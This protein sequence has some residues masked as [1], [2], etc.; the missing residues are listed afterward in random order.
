MGSLEATTKEMRDF[1]ELTIVECERMALP[2]HDVEVRL[3]AG[4]LQRPVQMP[5]LI[6]RHEP[7]PIAVNDQ[8][9]RRISTHVG[10]R[11]GSTRLIEAVLDVTP[12]HLRH[13]AE[14]VKMGVAPAQLDHVGRR[15]K[16]ARRVNSR[17]TDT[18]GD[19]RRQMPARRLTGNTKTAGINAV[20]MAIRVN[21]IDCGEGIFQLGGPAMR[22]TEQAILHRCHGESMIGQITQ[23]QMKP[24]M[25]VLPATPVIPHDYRT[26]LPR[27][28]DVK[29]DILGRPSVF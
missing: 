6:W 22:S 29:V 14:S 24:W 25:S 1:V 16:D 12:E 19:Q 26:R 21:P 5:R 17:A 8:E 27:R 9:R 20:A 28:G 10:K 13:D 3:G 7:I 18:Q 4:F 15:I 2:L 11:A 23:E